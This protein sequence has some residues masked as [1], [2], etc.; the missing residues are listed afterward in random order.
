RRNAVLCRNRTTAL[1]TIAAGVIDGYEVRK[2]RR[3]L[4]DY[5][6]LIDKTLE[7]LERFD[8]AWVHYKLDRGIDHVL[9]DEAQD[10]SPRQ[11][12]IIKALT[13][14]F[15]AGTGARL[16]KRTIFAVG[17]EKQSIYSFQ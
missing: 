17:D 8:S 6:D 7:L 12:R 16:L 15:F 9:V 14:E 1:I 2:D 4:L 3:G 5:D 13:T 10:T 11:W